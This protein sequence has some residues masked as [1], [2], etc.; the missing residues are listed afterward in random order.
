MKRNV[1]SYSSGKLFRIKFDDEKINYF[2]YSDSSGGVNPL[3][4]KIILNFT[5]TF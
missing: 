3:Y 2:K 1:V 5:P 4:H